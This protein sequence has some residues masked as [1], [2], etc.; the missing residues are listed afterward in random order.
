MGRNLASD[1]LYTDNS[2]LKIQS[3]GYRLKQYFF[4]QK[5]IILGLNP[6]TGIVCCKVAK[7]EIDDNALVLSRYA[8]SGND[9]FELF[10]K[11]FMIYYIN[12]LFINYNLGG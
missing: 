2:A 5:N 9:F 3:N 7:H 8:G 4:L 1:P 11:D 6:D 12:I 10:D